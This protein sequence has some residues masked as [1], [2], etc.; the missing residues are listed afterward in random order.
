[1]ALNKTNPHDYVINVPPGST[2]TGI[3][4]IFFPIWVWVNWYWIRFIT[5]SYTAPLSLESSEYSRD[6]IRSD[7]FKE[8]FPEIAIKVDKDTKSNFR[9]VQNQWVHQGNAPRQKLGGNRFSTSVGGSVTG[10]HGHILL[11]D[12]PIDPLKAASEKE[13]KTANYWMDKV[14][15]FRKVNKEVTCTVVIMQRVH[16][17]DPSGHLLKERKG[18]I[19]HICIPGE[20][21]NYRDQV[22]PPEL[23][24][25]YKDDLLDPERLSWDALDNYKILGQFTYGSQIGQKPTALEG[26]LFEIDKIGY[27]DVEPRDIEIDD[28]VRY[29]DKAGTVNGGAFSAGVKICQ[30]RDGTFGVLHVSRGQW[31]SSKREDTIK[32]IANRDGSHIDI[33]I[34]Q[35]P[36][37]GGKESAE[38]TVKNLAGFKVRTDR[39]TG[40]KVDRADPFSVQV[41]AGNVWLL[42]G[43]WNKEYLDELEFFPNST[44]KDQVDASSGAFN[45]LTK[46]RRVKIGRP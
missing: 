14:L 30:M 44:Y 11:I 2:K 3:V 33:G 38:N 22:Q 36:G 23:V 46:S 24:Q 41:N 17:N 7:R 5:G 39:P 21:R 9:V 13:I 6:I 1:M 25:Y 40:N 27:R 45:L 8:L 32:A 26:S 35:E 18:R 15:P 28:V 4:M 37:S 34:E 43:D 19:K 16:Q 10:F 20:I 12:D 42:R 29:W 31:G